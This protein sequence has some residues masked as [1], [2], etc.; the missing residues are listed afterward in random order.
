MTAGELKK[1]LINVSDDVII[2]MEASDHSFV[3]A[4]IN[5][6]TALFSPRNNMYTEDWG[7]EHNLPEHGHRIP[8]IIIY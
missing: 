8:A 6:G 7:D 5:V 4:D 2:L 1:I 3:K